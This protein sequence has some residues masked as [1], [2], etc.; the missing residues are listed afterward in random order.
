MTSGCRIR[1]GD[2]PIV[3]AT[4]LIPL[5]A[6]AWLDLTARKTAGDANVKGDDIK[7][8]RNDVFRLYRSLVPNDRFMLPERPRADLRMFLERHPP[9]SADWPAI[10]AA[11]GNPHLPD[12]ATVLAQLRTIFG[13]EG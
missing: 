3:T 8:H 5:K 10:H 6:R 12:A 4:A 2:L 7:K 11:V 1:S 9:G 13:G